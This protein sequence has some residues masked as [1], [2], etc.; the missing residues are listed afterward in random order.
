MHARKPRAL[1]ALAVAAMLA[2]PLPSIAA[3]DAFLKLDGIEGESTDDKHKGEIVIESWSF[4][5]ASRTLANGI[6]SS[7]PCLSDISFV[8]PVDKATPAL[9][10]AAMTGARIAT[11][12][13]TARK[14][15]E[16]PVEYLIVTMKDVMVSSVNHTSGGDV[17]MEGLSLA[18]A[19]MTLAYIG[20]KADGSLLPA[21]QTTVSGKC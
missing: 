7:R 2:L 20:Q 9:L 1:R 16:R 4:G 8:K 15:G 12:V 13:L 19:S 6:A 14:S 21:V 5:A 17:P 11:A 18:Y 10:G 3:F